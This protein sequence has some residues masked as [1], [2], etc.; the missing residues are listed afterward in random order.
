MLELEL[1]CF[2]AGMAMVAGMVGKELVPVRVRFMFLT[3]SQS[4]TQM[5]ARARESVGE[6]WDYANFS[7]WTDAICPWHCWFKKEGK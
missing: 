1:G 2:G 3:W 7:V 4:K 5:V 6:I